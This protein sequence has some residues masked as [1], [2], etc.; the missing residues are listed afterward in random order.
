MNAEVSLLNA[1]I[2]QG[3]I[4]PAIKVVNNSFFKVDLNKSVYLFMVQFYKKY[5]KVPSAKII[6][7]KFVDYNYKEENENIE[8]FVEELIERKYHD[9]L[10]KILD[11]SAE[12][13]AAEKASGVLDF[14]NSRVLD[15]KVEVKKEED[16]DIT[17]NTSDRF[18]RYLKIASSEKE[19]IRGIPCGLPTID[20]LTHGFHEGQVISLMGLAKSGKSFLSLFFAKNAWLK[21]YK[22]LYISLEMNVDQVMA[23]FD[24]LVTG[25]SH[26]YI[27]HGKL[28]IAEVEKYKEYL[29]TLH[30]GRPKFIISSPSMCNQSTV[31]SK[32]IEHE[33]DICVVDYVSLMQ[34]ERGGKEW[35]AIDNIMRDL[36][37]MARDKK[38]NIPIVVIAQVNRGFES[39]SM[40]L[41]KIENIAHSFTIVAHSDIVMALHQNKDLK[42]ENQMLFGIIANRDGTNEDMRLDWDLTNSIIKERTVA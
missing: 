34:D 41:P 31:Y 35:Q 11:E 14:I 21:G 36:K 20:N 3:H 13:L 5:S 39:N 19:G 38:I 17:K 33:P 26:S 28:N 8:F 12:K 30:E 15:I 37:N 40:E 29:R 9:E 7:D 25:L 42:E 18:D 23:R 4:I 6:K 16:V 22:P 2:T 1:I 27:K 10:L 32:I 24:A